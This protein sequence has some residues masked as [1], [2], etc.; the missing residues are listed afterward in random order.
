MFCKIIILVIYFFFFS[1]S[2]ETLTFFKNPVIAF[3]GALTG[4]P[5]ISLI[6]LFCSLIRLPHEKINLNGVKL[7][8]ILIFLDNDKLFSII[9][10]VIL[11]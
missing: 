7:E 1:F 4:G 6:E 8:F 10:S 2:L 3:S 9:I 11:F 5:F